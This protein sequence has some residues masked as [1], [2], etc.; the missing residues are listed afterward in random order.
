ML[1]LENKSSNFMKIFNNAN[2]TNRIRVED[3]GQGVTALQEGFQ[4]HLLQVGEPAVSALPQATGA[5]LAYPKDSPVRRS[6]SRRV[7]GQGHKGVEG[8]FSLPITHYQLPIP[9]IK[10]FLHKKNANF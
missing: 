3:W 6:R 5:R 9:I 7:G 4:R 10:D 2:L 1:V 8:K